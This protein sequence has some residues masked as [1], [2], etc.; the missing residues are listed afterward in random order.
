M[1]N[2]KKF[3]IIPV[4]FLLVIK[5]IIADELPS[6]RYVISKDGLNQRETASISS[7]KIG[8]LLYGTRIIIYSKNDQ[9][10]TF[11]GI[12]DYWYKSY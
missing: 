1:V 3:W 5:T 11:D 4:I 10:S 9:K 6:V 2:N 7:K 12:T 8:T